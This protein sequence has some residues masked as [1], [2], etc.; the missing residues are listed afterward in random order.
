M[1]STGASI[2]STRNT[3]HSSLEGFLGLSETETEADRR[4]PRIVSEVVREEAGSKAKGSFEALERPARNAE[5][6]AE[7]EVELEAVAEAAEAILLNS[8]SS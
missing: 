6:E 5:A 2:V 3:G 1:A 4:R 8:P 7:L